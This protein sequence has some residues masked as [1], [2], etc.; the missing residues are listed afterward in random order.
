MNAGTNVSS[1]RSRCEDCTYRVSQVAPHETGGRRHVVACNGSV[2]AIEKA[3]RGVLFVIVRE[4][5]NSSERAQQATLSQ[6]PSRARV[7]RKVLD[8]CAKGGRSD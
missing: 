1:A 7:L 8:R 2:A 5:G 4:C 6:K 3:Y